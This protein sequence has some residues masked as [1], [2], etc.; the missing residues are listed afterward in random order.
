[1]R[2][3]GIMFLLGGF[4]WIA[5]ETI[6]TFPSIQYTLWISQTKQISSMDSISVEEASG[7][8]RDV[9]LALNNRNHILLIPGFLM[10]IGGSFC[11]FSN[12]RNGR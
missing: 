1:M 10:L 3:L 4:I 8:I 5:C 9:C 12:N 7:R 6:I 11:C 2:I